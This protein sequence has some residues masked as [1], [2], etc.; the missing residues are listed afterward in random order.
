MKKEVYAVLDRWKQILF[1]LVCYYTCTLY[2][3][4]WRC[5]SVSRMAWWLLQQS[6]WKKKANLIVSWHGWHDDKTSK[7]THQQ[8]FIHIFVDWWDVWL[9]L[10]CMDFEILLHRR[11]G[12]AR[13]GP[14]GER[15]GN[16]WITWNIME[17]ELWTK[18]LWM[19]F[20]Q[21]FKLATFLLKFDNTCDKSC[22]YKDMN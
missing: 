8:L 5:I 13:N 17:N 11:R 15:E 19:M 2:E 7:M 1:P 9:K 21:D 6:T 4:K 12:E 18:D 22:S 3:T 16:L 10:Q 20:V 14:C